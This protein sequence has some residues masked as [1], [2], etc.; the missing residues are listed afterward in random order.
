[1]NGEHALPDYEGLPYSTVLDLLDICFLEQTKLSSFAVV[2]MAWPVQARRMALFVTQ[3]Q[4]CNGTVHHLHKSKHC[5]LSTTC[6]L[7]PNRMAASMKIGDRATEKLI[8][9][10]VNRGVE[11]SVAERVVTGAQNAIRDWTYT[12]SDFLSPPESAA[13]A[14]TISTIPNIQVMSWGGYEDAE[15]TAVICAHNEIGS[16]PDILLSLLQDQFVLLKLTGNFESSKGRIQNSD[17]LLHPRA[18]GSN[19]VTDS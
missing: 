3:G 16:T 8:A 18:V 4:F 17:Q 9:I 19:V 14:N 15:R 13:L 2:R 6:R 11:R 10:S 1:M 5:N 12:A 7:R